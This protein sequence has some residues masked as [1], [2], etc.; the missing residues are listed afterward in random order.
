VGG[1]GRIPEP[2][3][4]NTVL[5]SSVGLQPYSSLRAVELWI[6]EPSR[7]SRGSVGPRAF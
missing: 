1:S 2:S 3:I 6:P 5:E 4:T 7:L